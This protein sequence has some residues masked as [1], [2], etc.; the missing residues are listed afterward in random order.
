MRR[1]TLVLLFAVACAG[2]APS[3]RADA[4]PPVGHVF[5]IV[6]EN[7]GFAETFG[8]AGAVAAPYLSTTLPAIGELLTS[9]HGVGHGSLVNYIAMISGQPPTPDTKDNCSDPLAAVAPD[10]VPPYGV[11][12]TNGCVYPANFRTV[13]DQLT[14]RGLTWKGYMEDIPSPC[15]LGA[16]GTGDY[17]RRHNP[18]VFFSSLIDSG[19]CGVNDVPLTDLPADLADPN[20]TPN[21]AFITPNSCNDGHSACTPSTPPAPPVSSSDQQLHQIDAFLQVW[22]PQILAS[23]AFQRDGLLVVT[24]DEADD[25]AS[26]CNQQPGPAELTQPTALNPTPPLPRLGGGLIGAVLVSPFISPG[27]E[28]P[29]GAHLNATDYNH[30]S[31]L[32]SVEDL[33]GLT[34]LGYAAQDGLQP[35]GTDVFDRI[36]PPDALPEPGLTPEP[37]GG[38]GSATPPPGA[39]PSCSARPQATL[40]PTLR[41]TARGLAV[42]G[43]AT[44]CGRIRVVEVA[45]ARRTARRD[46]RWLSL[47]AKPGRPTSCGR[48]FWLLATTVRGGWSVTLRGRLSPGHYDVLVRAIDAA[49]RKQ[50]VPTRRTLV[51]RRS[52]RR[53]T[54]APRRQPVTPWAA[55]PSR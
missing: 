16:S 36:P 9:Y 46:C 24:F 40:A 48:P 26:C 32:R 44:G 17:A 34:H 2:P 47:A 29:D 28:N 21:F 53:R 43:A 30:S 5:V 50:L 18:F 23:P 3:A 42:K 10:A 55:L 7:K 37:H 22:V 14:E 6:M 51:V 49:G 52:K 19:Q 45:V 12:A 1:L 27:A 4:L 33:F 8:P 15:F 20:H 13:A 31:L 25:S 11:A 41:P 54:D 35:F 38:A 39:Q